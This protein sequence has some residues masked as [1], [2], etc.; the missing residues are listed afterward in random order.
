MWSVQPLFRGMRPLAVD[1][2][3]RSSV[4]MSAF[5]DAVLAKQRSIAAAMAQVFAELSNQSMAW[6]GLAALLDLTH[7]HAVTS[8]HVLCADCWSFVLAQKTHFS[9]HV[10]VSELRNKTNM[11]IMLLVPGKAP[12]WLVTHGEVAVVRSV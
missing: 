4:R 7:N 3:H 6:F 8:H 2:A 11:L 5:G 9:L 1:C 10:M 12:L